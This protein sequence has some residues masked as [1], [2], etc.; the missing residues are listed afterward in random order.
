MALS[1]SF[2]ND[3]ST[4]ISRFSFNSIYRVSLET[5]LSEVISF[6]L[7]SVFWDTLYCL[8]IDLVRYNFFWKIKLITLGKNSRRWRR[9]VIFPS[10]RSNFCRM[11]HNWISCSICCRTAKGKKKVKIHYV[12]NVGDS[13]A[14]I[15]FIFI[16]VQLMNTKF[17]LFVNNIQ[18]IPQKMFL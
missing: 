4:L 13:K 3:K 17:Y 18:G 12:G 7:R 16:K 14:Y 8:K 15:D 1:K 9:A 10:C 5:L 6:S 11:V 2:F